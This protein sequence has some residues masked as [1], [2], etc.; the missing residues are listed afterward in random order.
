MSGRRGLDPENSFAALFG[1]ELARLRN[2]ANMSQADL[3]RKIN[4]SGGH[5]SMVEIAKRPPSREFA[6]SC[7][8]ALNTGGLLGRLWPFVNRDLFPAWFQ[9]Y[10]QLEAEATK[11]QTYECQTIPGMLQTEGYAR[12][13]LEAGWIQN[14][15]EPL[16]ARMERQE[17]L[18]DSS[19]PL[20][21]ALI[22][23]AVTRRPVGGHAVMREQLK[24]LADLATS[25]R[26]VLQVVPDDIG[27]HAC[28]DGSM[29][30]LSFREGSDVAY[31]EGPG[32]GQLI[33]RP[34]DVAQ[35]QQRYDLTRAVALSPQASIRMITEAMEEA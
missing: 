23:E 12:A 22:D 25:R 29:T 24:C 15:D 14:I 32:S 11:I 20:M 4:F 6:E 7:D 28:M 2:A 35:C 33:D 21:W 18:R 8:E 9:G 16:A 10:V 31:V 34:E 19:R 27:A 1:A 3:G 26:I 17:I 5:V 30:L 13:V